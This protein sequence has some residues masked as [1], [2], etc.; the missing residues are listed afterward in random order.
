M[1]STDLMT[2][3]VHFADGAKVDVDAETPGKAREAARTYFKRTITKIKRLS[4]EGGKAD[5]PSSAS[6]DAPSGGQPPADGDAAVR[7]E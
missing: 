7:T 6:A 2:F 4:A 5:R 3:R 1:S